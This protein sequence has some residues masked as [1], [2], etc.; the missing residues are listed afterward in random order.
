MKLPKVE[1]LIIFVFFGC[2][3]LWAASKCSSERADFVRHVGEIGD[4]EQE[5]RPVHRDTIVVQQPVVQQP[6]QQQPAAPPPVQQLPVNT[7]RPS[8]V[9]PVG[10]SPALSTPAQQPAANPTRPALSNQPKPTSVQPAATSAKYSTLYV[11][12]D[13]LNVRK[14]PGLKSETVAKLALYEQVFFLNQK[15][16]WTQ[17]ISL[18]KEK[19]TDHW[20][21][22]R[23][24]AGKEG[25]VFGAGVHY[26]KMKRQ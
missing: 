2:V 6:V 5:D 11:S 21:K 25:W 16:E 9:A 15:T 1:T 23:T 3:A 19:V 13:G 12:I 17:E 7:Q 22:V 14:E 20:V 18:G 8:T 10:Q 26:Y 24:K 4:D